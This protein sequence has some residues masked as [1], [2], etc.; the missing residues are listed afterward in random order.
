MEATTFVSFGGEFGGFF[1]VYTRGRAVAGGQDVFWSPSQTVERCGEQG[2][3]TGG[4]FGEPQAS[5]AGAAP[6]PRD[7]PPIVSPRL[8]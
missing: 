4:A 2:L 6:G 1:S 7:D 5:G 8:L 3:S